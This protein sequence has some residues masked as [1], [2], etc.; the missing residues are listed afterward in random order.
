[1]EGGSEFHDVGNAPG[2]E[3]VFESQRQEELIP[4]LQL[5]H[6]DFQGLF[7][8]LRIGDPIPGLRLRESGKSAESLESQISSAS[9]LRVSRSNSEVEGR[10]RPYR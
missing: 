1:M 2:G 8:A 5:F 10:T 4:W 6:G 3:S 7:A 9:R